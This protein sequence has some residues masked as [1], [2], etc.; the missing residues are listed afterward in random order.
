MREDRLLQTFLDLV[1]IDSPSG[2]EEKVRE[3]VSRFVQKLGLEPIQDA[4]GNL[5]VKIDGVGEPILLGS[6]LD[7]VEPGKNIHPKIEDGIIKSDGTTILG[8]DNKVAV[9]A[10]LEVLKSVIESKTKTKPLDIIFTLAEESGEFGST[11]LDYSKIN[12]EEGYTFDSLSPLGSIITASPFYNRFH[13]KIIGKATHASTPDEGINTLKIL[14]D[15]IGKIKLGKVNDKTV[16]NIGVVNGGSG[17]NT[18]PGE[19]T[20]GG[21]VRSFVGEDA[22]F[23]SRNIVQ[24]FKETALQLG[25]KIEA[26]IFQDSPGYEYEADDEFIKSTKK[27]IEDL[28]LIPTLVKK[29]A[30]SDAN[31]LHANGIKTLNLGDG[32]NDPH[33]VKESVSIESLNLLAKLVSFL[34][35]PLHT[36]RI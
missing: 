3:Y 2:H 7:T 19:T 10:I 28:R 6:H 9:A 35:I 21:E 26:E 33:T 18:I 12:A 31:V 8:A 32:I 1:K 27:T 14:V 16:M 20:I 30:C 34:I 24:K 17:I 15:S 29:W 23:Y 11:K 13:I 22:E 5:I 4:R 36:A 25:G